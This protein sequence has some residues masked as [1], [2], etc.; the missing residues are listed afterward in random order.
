MAASS[1]LPARHATG[2]GT[3]MPGPVA[4]P[5]DGAG[6]GRHIVAAFDWPTRHADRLQLL[7]GTTIEV[8]VTC[9][10]FEA[11]C[12]PLDAPGAAARVDL[13]RRSDVVGDA[14][15]HQI[16]NVTFGCSLET[17]VRGAWMTT[18]TSPIHHT[19]H[20]ARRRTPA[21]PSLLQPTAMTATP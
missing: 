17:R 3:L 14:L 11:S 19:P 13:C 1:V 4:E 16:G 6:S 20:P 18:A 5:F 8:S 21:A 7:V 15:V 2:A 12:P 10:E 9:G